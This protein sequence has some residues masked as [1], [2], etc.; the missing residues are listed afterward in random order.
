MKK[1][2]IIGCPGSGKSTFAKKLHGITGIPLYH[3]DLIW[4]LPQRTTVSRE[5]F[6]EKLKSILENDEWI[7]DGNYNRTL[8]IRAEHCDTLFFLDLPVEECI[9]GVEKR[10]GKKRDDMPWIEECFDPE[11]RRWI[12]DFPVREYGKIKSIIEKY[13]YKN[14]IV[15]KS[16]TEIDKYLE[17]IKKGD[18]I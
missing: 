11:F 3:L 18:R 13:S 14:I 8:E 15:F 9:A 2:M 6:D 5:E 1:I 12:I 7:I 16:R 17:D 4:H 10:I